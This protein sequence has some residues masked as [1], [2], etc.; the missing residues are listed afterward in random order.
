M[1]NKK[2]QT[3]TQFSEISGVGQAKL[4]KYAAPFIKVITDY[5]ETKKSKITTHQKTFNLFK[6]GKTVSEISKERNV[7]ESTIFSHLVK[8]HKEGAEIDL[9]QFITPEELKKIK[10][11]QKTLENPDGLR[12]YFD[13]F[14]EKISYDILK[15]GLYLLLK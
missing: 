11:A 7:S 14:E 12:V 2:P 6:E 15:L 10:A 3:V 8:M 9:H 13:H 1:E 4:D 5:L